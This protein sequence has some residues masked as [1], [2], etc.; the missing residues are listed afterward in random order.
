MNFKA[1]EEFCNDGVYSHRCHRCGKI[2][3]NK[4]GILI[5]ESEGDYGD[6]HE[7]HYIAV[8]DECYKKQKRG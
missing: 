6:V 3:K 8:C 5:K 1:L 4:G 2:T 7:V